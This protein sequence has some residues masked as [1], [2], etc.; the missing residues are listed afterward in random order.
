MDTE[1]ETETEAEAEAEAEEEENYPSS[2]ED[3][4]L[5]AG[6]CLSLIAAMIFSTVSFGTE[7]ALPSLSIF[8]DHEKLLK[9][10]VGTTGAENIGGEP[11][12]IIDAIA[13]IG[14]WLEHN[15]HF[16][17]GPLEDDDFLQHLQS[18]S[19]LSANSPSPSLRYACHVLTSSIL[20]AHPDDRVRLAFIS[21]TLEHCPYETL[22]ESAIGWLKDELMTAQ[23]RKSNNVFSSSA[24]IT[25]VQPYIFPEIPSVEDGNEELIQQLMQVYPLHMGILN[26]LY[27]LSGSIY[28]HLVPQGLIQTTKELYLLP[29]KEV[30][31]KCLKDLGDGPALGLNASEKEGDDVGQAEARLLGEQLSQTSTQVELQLLGDRLDLYLSKIEDV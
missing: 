5:S 18:L 19:L 3:I 22:K 1:P 28:S 24:A 27:F 31:D 26:F 29:L 2:P 15:N 11:I 21:D 13:T 25:A 23:A 9:R 14:L 10:F 20:H 4:P 6:G 30:L 7:S 16:V 12:G 8:P 17:S